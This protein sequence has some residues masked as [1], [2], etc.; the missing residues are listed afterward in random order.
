MKSKITGL[1]KHFAVGIMTAFVV[2]SFTACGGASKD[3]IKIGYGRG[4]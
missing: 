2:L 3:T 4:L 1:L